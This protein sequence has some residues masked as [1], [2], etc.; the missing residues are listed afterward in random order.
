MC[1][2]G[3]LSINIKL[4][5]LVL[6][7]Q[8]IS[9]YAQDNTSNAN[10]ESSAAGEVR[11]ELSDS[12]VVDKAVNKTDLQDK[13]YR[14]AL[15]HYFQDD[16]A[17]ALSQVEQS[18]AK[19]QRLDSRSSLFEAGLQLS[20]GLLQQA[21]KTLVNFD[22]LLIAEKNNKVRDR[23]SAKANDLLLISLLSLTD[24]YL[25][26]GDIRQA[27]ETLARIKSVSSNYYP[28]Y[29]VLSQLAYW[30]N[31]ATLLPIASENN[32][33]TGSPY[34][35]LNDALRLIEKSRSE[36][37]GAEPSKAEQLSDGQS[38]NVQA[39]NGQASYEQAISLLTTI[40]TTRWQERSPDFWKTLFL[41]EV[42]FASQDEEKKMQKSQ[43]QAIQDYAQL[44][45]AQIYISQQRYQLAFKELETFPQHSP[46][47]ESAL[48][49][50]AFAS[51]EVG[52]YEIALNLLT[53]L[54]KNYPYS[55]LGWQSAEL[56]AEQV[57][58]QR[59]LAQGVSA[60]QQ[61]EYFF[62]Q[63]QQNLT[64]F[65]KAFAAQGDLLEFSPV[66][67][68]P[69]KT[70]TP[71]NS[72]LAKGFQTDSVWLQQALYDAELANLY[73]GL[74]SI[75]EQTVRV[76][77]LLNKTTWL[78]EIITLNQQRKAHIV[79]TT[80]ARNYSALFEQLSDERDRLAIILN[81]QVLNN[82]HTIFADEKERQWLERIKHSDSLLNKIEGKK[83]TEDYLQRLARV[84]G[85]LSW[86]LAQ[87]NPSRMWTHKKQLQNIDKA[88]AGVTNQQQKLKKISDKD[89]SLGVQIE[90]H[91][92]SIKQLD[93]QLIQAAMLREKF[94]AKIRTKVSHYIDGQNILL[95]EH[96]LSTRQGMANVLER[97][98]KADKKL[99]RQLTPRQ[100]ITTSLLAEP[101]LR[102][103]VKPT[104]D[105]NVADMAGNF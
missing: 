62:L 30:P 14:Q 67:A 92:Q 50:F 60:Y 22:E 44:L 72:K 13:Y 64:N 94:S 65:E 81:Q 43:G 54:Y 51:Q 29:H 37:L 55:A 32:E 102:R 77:S 66:K 76:Q 95:A 19:L 91:Q 73:Q 12:K 89:D 58:D 93:L 18:R 99:S 9:V 52:Q 4:L 24:Q 80:K 90:K 17:Q 74:R 20:E 21:K 78:A 28:Q 61:V 35:L 85:V 38:I 86:Q 88:I 41:N 11:A 83:N 105:D 46:Y 98:A 7:C 1:F 53:L 39:I 42:S 34:I 25:A 40:K 59:S 16:H 49:L 103:A 27:R 56:M 101:D 47:T 45:L 79:S 23:K 82:D 2:K 31:N 70:V 63:R 15:Y 6:S 33:S 71:Q 48:F 69:V 8:G 3:V 26:Q 100:D 10:N 87:K 97:M 36:Q 96:L 84:Q 57:S 75:D 5:L 68:M 104:D